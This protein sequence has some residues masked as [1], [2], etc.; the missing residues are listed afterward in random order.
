M[1]PIFQEEGMGNPCLLS[2]LE[3]LPRSVDTEP[4]QNGLN[5]KG[6]LKAIRSH[7][8]QCTGTPTAPSVLRAP[9]PDLGCLQ[10]WGTTTSL[11]NLCKCFPGRAAAFQRL[12]RTLHDTARSPGLQ[13]PCSASLWEQ[14]A[15]R[16]REE[17]LPI[18]LPECSAQMCIPRT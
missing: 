2:I 15:E 5:W 10:G 11:G 1:T 8:L 3:S 16:A 6:P 12:P 14:L 9:S 18:V 17:T 7:S 13:S 4:S